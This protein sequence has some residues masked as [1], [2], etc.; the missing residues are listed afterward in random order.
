ME[1]FCSTVATKIPLI[2]YFVF[3]KSRL[4][5]DFKI[6]VNSFANQEK[7]NEILSIPHS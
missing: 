7:E 1:A 3:R 5:V 6:I 2:T 4:G